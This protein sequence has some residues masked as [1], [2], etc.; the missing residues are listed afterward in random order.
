MKAEI[1][2]VG[3]ELLLG[4]IAN[5]NGQF[6]SQQLACIG[7][8]VHFH[9]VVGDNE[10]RLQ[11]ALVIA[12]SRAD[13][14]IL[15]G[16]LGP[17]KDDLTKEV[18][19]HFCKRPLV[20][21]LKSV[22]AMEDYFSSSG[23]PMTENNRK[24]ALVIAQSTVLQ[25]KHGL[26]PGM[27]YTRENGKM[28]VLLPGPPKEMKPMVLNELLPLLQG[29]NK[30]MMIKS[31]VLRFFGIGEATIAAKL[32]SLLQTQTNPTIAPLANNDEVTLRLTIKHADPIEADRRLDEVEKAI[33]SQIG[34]YFYGY[35]D[36]SLA[37]E[38][39]L[40]LKM[41][42]WTIAVAE[43]LT[44]GLFTSELATISG[45]S[46]VLVGGVTAYSVSAKKSILG[47]SART[48]TDEGMISEACAHE[49]ALGVQALYQSDVAIALTGVAGPE[50]M[51]GQSVGTV[52]LAMKLP[53]SQMITK[54]LM[55]NGHRQTIRARAV[56]YSLFYL[57]EH[58][59]RG[60]GTK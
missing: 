32:D 26:A 34:N 2:A 41:Y 21:D 20:Y 50:E 17:T 11:S 23:H 14:F 38:V 30:Q 48:L 31:R 27:M 53:D 5:T 4:Q 37:K 47:V 29:G 15:T 43:S 33:C 24:Q 12:D 57:L 46:R 39:Y 22:R 35:D 8:D 40:R 16:G 6:L 1:I 42:D 44:A 49:M 59:K 25:N 52:W 58:L 51:E 3:S 7:I 56:K 55:I 60:I 36:T 54:R 28:I 19:A 9:T 18:V 13:L 10:H 45:V